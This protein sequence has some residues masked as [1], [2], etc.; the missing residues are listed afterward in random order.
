MRLA[1]RF[2]LPP[3]ML[4]LFV[5]TCLLYRLDQRD[6][7]EANHSHVVQWHQ[8][9]LIADFYEG[10][11]GPGWL[12]VAYVLQLPGLIPVAVFTEPM[13]MHTYATW[14]TYT[15]DVVSICLS[16]FLIGLLLDIRH[17]KKPPVLSTLS[18]RPQA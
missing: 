1:R 9:P 2:L 16:W 10:Y 5:A 18:I 4:V 11:R 3:T 8:S 13:P 6:W 15:A 12:G 17:R 14:T 7:E